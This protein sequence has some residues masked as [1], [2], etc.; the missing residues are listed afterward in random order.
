[1]G[2]RSDGSR[3]DA[4]A[5]SALAVV[6]AL[7]VD[8]GLDHAG[9]RA[10]RRRQDTGQLLGRTGEAT[11]QPRLQ[12][13]AVGDLRQGGGV[14]LTLL[15]LGLRGMLVPWLRSGAMVLN[16]SDAAVLPDSS[17]TERR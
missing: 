3:R 13:D 8:L 6:A 1:M 15:G 7:A 12:G 5:G 16:S 11:E 10:R 17:V 9:Q 4:G 2:T 14:G